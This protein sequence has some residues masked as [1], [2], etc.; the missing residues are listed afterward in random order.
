MG[1]VND[2]TA[3]VVYTGN[4]RDEP[5]DQVARNIVGDNG[6]T[7][8]EGLILNKKYKHNG[9]HQYVAQRHR[10]KKQ[11]GSRTT[12]TVISTNERSRK[13]N[14]D[15]LV[16]E[17]CSSES[18][19]NSEKQMLTY[20]G[21]RSQNPRWVWKARAKRIARNPTAMHSGPTYSSNI[22]AGNTQSGA[23][24]GSAAHPQQRTAAMRTRRSRAPQRGDVFDSKD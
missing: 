16:A 2:S 3:T 8:Y 19:S 15:D 14:V 4:A 10:R 18:T 6:G 11:K 1:I 17:I 13:L 9:R 24:A 20:S 7:L 5:I 21:T 22:R 12:Y 23:K